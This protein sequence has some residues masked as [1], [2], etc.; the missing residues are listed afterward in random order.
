MTDELELIPRGNTMS[1]ADLVSIL[2]AARNAARSRR[3]ACE[4]TGHPAAG[5]YGEIS[6]GLD[7]LIY[8]L[9]RYAYA[10]VK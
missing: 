7:D 2:R 9:S 6:V 10:K 4:E 8:R 3:S 1:I 5:L